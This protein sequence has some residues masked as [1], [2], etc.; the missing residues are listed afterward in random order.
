MPTRNAL[1]ALAAVLPLL[2]HVAAQKLDA[3]VGGLR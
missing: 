3:W 2:P 1:H